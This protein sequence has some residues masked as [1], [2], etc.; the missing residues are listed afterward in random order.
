MT[1]TKKGKMRK[2][3]QKKKKKQRTIPQ[4]SV[5][6][7][8][9]EEFAALKA[10]K[11]CTSI[12]CKCYCPPSYTLVRFI[13]ISAI[14]LSPTRLLP[15]TRDYEMQSVWVCVGGCV[16]ASVRP[17]VCHA[18]CSKTIV[19]TDF[20]SKKSPNEFLCPSIFFRFGGL[21]LQI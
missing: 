7:L 4:S 6:D 8:A 14:F 17:L 20:F 5:I 9:M 13:L 16:R 3:K 1:K 15:G 2:M 11:Y 21:G 12:I 10:G 18:D 19:V